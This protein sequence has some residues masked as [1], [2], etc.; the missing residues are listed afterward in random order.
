MKKTIRTMTAIGMLFTVGLALVTPLHADQPNSEKVNAPLLGSFVHSETNVSILVSTQLKTDA[1]CHLALEELRTVLE[2]KGYRAITRYLDKGDP[3]PDGNKIIVGELGQEIETGPF[4]FNKEA[5]RISQAK[6]N[7]ANVL[8]IEGDQRGGM[9]GVFKLAEQLQLGKD[10]WDISM[11]MA[12]EFSMRMYTE[13]GQ[14]YDLP[15]VGY[16]LFEAPWVNH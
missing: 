16:H 11:E 13:L 2:A 3:L 12:P 14:L 5:Y 4:S 6:D 7:A 15:S 1:G 10:L 9:Y 8:K